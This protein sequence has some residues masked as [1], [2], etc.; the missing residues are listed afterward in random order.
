MRSAAG[1]VS[2]CFEAGL[3]GFGYHPV[4]YP[5]A[6]WRRVCGDC[7]AQPTYDPRIAAVGRAVI[8]N[9]GVCE[10]GNG[11]FIPSCRTRGTR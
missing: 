1:A 10:A 3:Q 7:S 11:G 6:P 4:R 2:G 8:V 5:M 9:A